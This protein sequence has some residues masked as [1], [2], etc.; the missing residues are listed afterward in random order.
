MANIAMASAASS[1]EKTAELQNVYATTTNFAASTSTVPTAECGVKNIINFPQK[2][3][4]QLENHV[5]TSIPNNSA[6]SNVSRAR[7]SLCFYVLRQSFY[8][9]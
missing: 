3:T 8:L 7:V 9:H 2:S 4:V 1:T 6:A 5:S